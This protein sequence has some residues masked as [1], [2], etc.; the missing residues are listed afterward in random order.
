M[1]AVK[2]HLISVVAGVEGGPKSVAQLPSILFG[3]IYMLFSETGKTLQGRN[4]ISH[5]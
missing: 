1:L 4:T 2:S 3:Q 5:R